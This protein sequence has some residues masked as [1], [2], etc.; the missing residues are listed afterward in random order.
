MLDEEARQQLRDVRRGLNWILG[1]LSGHGVT[2]EEIALTAD[3]P[4]AQRKA[5]RRDAHARR[6]MERPKPRPAGT[7]AARKAARGKRR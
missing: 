2:R 3:A 4:P 6:A 5:A 1:V 7:K